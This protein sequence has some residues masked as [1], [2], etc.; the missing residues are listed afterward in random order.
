MRHSRETTGGLSLDDGTRVSSRLSSGNLIER[1]SLDPTVQKQSFNN[2]ETT[3][4]KAYT[5][6]GMNWKK[7]NNKGQKA[8]AQGYLYILV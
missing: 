8:E 3:N 2:V 6:W 4:K 1:G 7:A 5:V